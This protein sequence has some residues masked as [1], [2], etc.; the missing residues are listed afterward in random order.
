MLQKFK[1]IVSQLLLISAVIEIIFFFSVENIWATFILV[2]GWIVIKD[3]IL[4]Y[5]IMINYPVTFFM[6]FGVSIFHY[7]L[8]IPLTLIEFKPVTYNLICPFETFMHHGLVIIILVITH[9]IYRQ[10]T[11]RINPIRSILIRTNFYFKPNDTLIWFTASISII[12]SAYFYIFYGAW[13]NYTEK[14]IFITIGNSMTIFLWM[15]VIIPFYKVRNINSKLSIR[16]KIFIIIY[17]LL[18]FIISII[19]NWR[20]MLFSGITIFICM[21]IIGLLYGH[22]SLKKIFKPKKIISIII[23]L[24][25][26]LGPLMD[27]GVAMVVTRQSRYN[28]NSTEFLNKTIEVYQDKKLLNKVNDQLGEITKSNFAV[29]KW[30]EEYLNNYIF[31]RYCNLKISDNCIYYAQKIG[32]RNPKMQNVFQ[33][34]ILSYIPQAISKNINIESSLRKEEHQSSITDNLYSI[35]T[36][37]PTVKGSAIIGSLPGVGL[38]IFGYWYLII[39]IPIFILIFIIFDSFAIKKAGKVSFSYYFFTLIVI[40]FNFFNDRHVYD[41]ELR[42]ILRNFIESIVMFLLIMNFSKI[43]LKIIFNKKLNE[44]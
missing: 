12:Y 14:N 11:H 9:Y 40:T 34:L 24:F 28:T 44:N 31:N 32:Y 1:K 29:K 2:F 8:P 37:D 30:G 6:F 19:S 23:I 25:I 20:T 27:L 4:T 16:N 35:A 39:L 33:N 26:I 36:N 22:Y 5:K 38:S 3:F 18:V 13:E 10:F 43:I 7:I 21:Y 41:F 17:S 42:W 15:P